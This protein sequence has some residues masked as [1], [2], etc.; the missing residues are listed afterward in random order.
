MDEEDFYP[1][2]EEYHDQLQF[3]RGATFGPAVRRVLTLMSAV[4]LFATL[5]NS[6]HHYTLVSQF[7][8]W[9]LENSDDEDDTMTDH[10]SNDTDS[11]SATPPYRSQERS[12]FFELPAVAFPPELIHRIIGELA[13][14]DRSRF[15]QASSWTSAAI[16]AL[17][18]HEASTLL[19]R[20]G[21]RFL[22]VRLM[23]AATGTVIGGSAVPSLLMRHF[24]ANNI[25]LYA[26]RGY[27]DEVLHF[28]LQ[29]SYQLKDDT[30]AMEL[31]PGIRNCTTVALHGLE[32]NVF[33]TI[34]FNPLAA[35]LRSHLSVVFGAW[36]HEYV[37][38][39]YPR[40]TANWET[41]TTRTHLPRGA[42]VSEQQRLWKILKKYGA[43]G[44]EIF[45]NGFDEPHMCGS[46]HH[47]PATLR[48]TDDGASLR[49]RF[50][51][52]SYPAD[53]PRHG[54]VRWSMAGSG[55]AEG[56]TQEGGIPPL[57]S[58][59]NEDLAWLRSLQRIMRHSVLP[60]TD[61]N[62]PDAFL[63]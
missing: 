49:V 20:F 46:S 38:H 8:Q 43:N 36:G 19:T 5:S 53:G 33:E 59:H 51:A 47:C 45:L 60:T 10:S 7:L 15:A 22:E 25:D 40:L 56:L 35:V 61:D 57:S 41:I 37:W 34:S 42:G 26:G 48:T 44:F 28:L 32:I 18:A 12:S 27:D 4:Q 58:T 24:T 62:Y 54:P 52:L 63:E 50:P 30:L 17:I 31:P 23:Q 21:L 29:N 16:H 55:C 14:P 11:S 6:S 2:L 39:G 13:P 9:E 3:L 1:L